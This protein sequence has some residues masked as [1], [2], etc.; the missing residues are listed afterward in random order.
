MKNKKF[1]SVED[2]TGKT[3]S[4][5]QV[6]D[7]SEILGWSGCCIEALEYEAKEEGT[8]PRKHLRYFL[9]E[10]IFESSFRW[11]DNNERAERYRGTDYLFSFNIDNMKIQFFEILGGQ[12]VIEAVPVR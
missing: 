4:A 3:G 2:I 9:N 6:R 10:V 1:Y 5:G 8:T 7:Y 11:I 12:I